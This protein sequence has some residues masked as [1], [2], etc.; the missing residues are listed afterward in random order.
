MRRMRAFLSA[1]VAHTRAVALVFGACFVCAAPAVAQE[2]YRG[3]TVNIFIGFAA[4]GSYDY[5]GHL[6]ARH[7]GR[8]LPGNPA[9][10]ANAS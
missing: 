6:L 1:P 7:L 5:Y 2:F 4:G 10:V 3:K 9:V 8:N